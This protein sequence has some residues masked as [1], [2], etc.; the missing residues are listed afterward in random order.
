MRSMR[1][2]PRTDRSAFRNLKFRMTSIAVG[3]IQII[4]D[5]MPKKISLLGSGSTEYPQVYSPEILEAFENKHPDTDYWVELECPEFTSLCPR[6]AQPDFAVIHI[7]YIPDQ[8]LVE[9]KSLK[10]Y[11]FSFRNKGEFHENCVCTI[12]KDLWELLRP[13]YIEVVGDF[14]P[15][16][17]ISINPFS[18]RWKAGYE[19]LGNSRLKSFRDGAHS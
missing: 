19:D 4:E 17:G 15:R 8:F 10:L 7:R 14:Y 13:K 11:L 12:L 5:F 6:T 3:D 18:C 9:S 2:L 16:G 1:Y